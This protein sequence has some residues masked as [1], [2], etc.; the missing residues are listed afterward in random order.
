MSSR[1]VLTSSSNF[2][3]FAALGL[4]GGEPMSSLPVRSISR[5]LAFGLLPVIFSYSFAEA[6][7]IFRDDDRQKSPR[8]LGASRMG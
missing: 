8:V 1:P 6:A 4:A 3:F 7:R 5:P 2:C